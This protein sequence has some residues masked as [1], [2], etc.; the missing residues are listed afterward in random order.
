MIAALALTLAPSSDLRAMY[1]YI[2]SLGPAG[3]NAQ[4]HLPP[5]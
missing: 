2:R 1:Q 4:P 3:H 5:D